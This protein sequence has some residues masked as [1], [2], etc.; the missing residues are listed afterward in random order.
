M[1]KQPETINAAPVPG[2]AN[3]EIVDIVLD[4]DDE[5]GN[6]LLRLAVL[7]D[8]STNAP[9]KVIFYTSENN[10]NKIVCIYI[11]KI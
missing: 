10:S 2:V 8:R 3:F 11:F 7:C 1:M 6:N 9:I 5:E 4:T